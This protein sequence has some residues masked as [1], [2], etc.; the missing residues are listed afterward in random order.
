MSMEPDI[1]S[2]D[3]LWDFVLP[4][5]CLIASLFLIYIIVNMSK[6]ILDY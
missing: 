2:T 5:F 3:W 4:I 6:Y 1:K